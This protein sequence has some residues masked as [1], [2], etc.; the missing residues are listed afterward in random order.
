MEAKKSS[1]VG[2][3]LEQQVEENEHVVRRPRR[4]TAGELARVGVEL[5]D[6][7]GVRLKC[8]KCGVVWS[9]NVGRHGRLP[10]GWWKCPWGCNRTIDGKAIR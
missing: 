10:R 4:C 7:A 5:I 3:K 1:G 9:P 6:A 8:K 2:S